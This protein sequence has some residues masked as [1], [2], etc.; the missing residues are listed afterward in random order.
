MSAWVASS[1]LS[2]ADEII[3]REASFSRKVKNISS[4][5]LQFL[6]VSR[7]YCSALC[8]LI[9]YL[10]DLQGVYKEQKFCRDVV[11]P[12]AP[13]YG[14]KHQEGYNVTTLRDGPTHPEFHKISPSSTCSHTPS[15]SQDLTLFNM[16][17]HT[18]NITRS[19]PPQHVPTH[20]E[21][22]KI[23]PSSTWSHTPRRSQ[24]LT[25]YNMVPHTQKLTRSH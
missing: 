20:P 23:S 6:S 19:H 21:D 22:H 13:Q 25:L 11:F 24:D 12:D 4:P 16:V 15:R 5:V 7:Q 8:S 18:Q 17:P 9:N 3:V 2:Q 1:W 14:A 10:W